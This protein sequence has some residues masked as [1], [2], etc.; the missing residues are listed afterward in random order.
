MHQF[1]T[2][3]N[4]AVISLSSG[5]FHLTFYSWYQHSSKHF[6]TLTPARRE[7]ETKQN[8][9]KK[10]PEDEEDQDE[11]DECQVIYIFPL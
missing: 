4:T 5:P 10:E 9:T 8:N 6:Y 3:T 1:N 7:K 2:N 11:E